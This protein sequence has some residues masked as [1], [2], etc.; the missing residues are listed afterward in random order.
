MEGEN[1]A[2]LDAVLEALMSI[3]CGAAD[4]EAQL[5]ALAAQALALAGIEAEHEA[6]LAPRCRID[7]MAGGVGIEIKKKRPERA[8]LIAQLTRY[9]ACGQV[10][11]LAVVAPRGVD[12]PRAIS[13]KPVRMLALERLWGISLP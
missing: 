11:A 8:R 13:G 3:R 4:T 10:R 9:A 5:H 2:A 7:F 1:A 6:R 12:L